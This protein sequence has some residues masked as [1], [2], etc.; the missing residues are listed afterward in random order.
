MD[1]GL[2]ATFHWRCAPPVHASSAQAVAYGNSIVQIRNVRVTGMTAALKV[3][4]K[5]P[6]KS[7]KILCNRTRVYPNSANLLSRSAAVDMDGRAQFC[8]RATL[9][10]LWRPVAR[11]HPH[12]PQMTHPPP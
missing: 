6:L 5:L 12:H 2:F 8:A 10:P 3:T 4:Q 9:E 7:P 11:R 1:K